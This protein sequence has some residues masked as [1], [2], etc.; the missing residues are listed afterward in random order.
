MKKEQTYILDSVVWL[1]YALA[2]SGTLI[3]MYMCIYF[4]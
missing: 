1:D 3:Q 4:F 2:N